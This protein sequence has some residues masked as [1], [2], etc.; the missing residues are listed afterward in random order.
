MSC[1]ELNK[2]ADRSN[3]DEHNDDEWE[4]SQFDRETAAVVLKV[5]TAKATQRLLF[6]LQEL[7]IFKAQWLSNYCS[8]NPPSG[9]NKFLLEML[10][11]PSTTV[12]DATNATSHTID[13]A[14]LAHRIVQI[15]SE[16]AS[17]MTKFPKFVEVETTEVLRQHLMRSTYVSG[18]STGG[19]GE[20]GD[21]KERR[22]YH[23]PRN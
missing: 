10:R 11:Q 13:P 16:M 5:L 6:Q 12:V 17:G 14:N 2:W 1:N 9:S 21:Y 7:D 19:S 18:T 15:R 23:R 22:G 3:Y 8:E 4:K 20:R